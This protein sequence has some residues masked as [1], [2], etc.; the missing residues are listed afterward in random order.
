MA[1]AL[2]FKDFAVV[3]MA[4]HPV[5][6]G[7]DTAGMVNIYPRNVVFICD[8]L[9]WRKRRNDAG[10]EEGRAQPL[11]RW[12]SKESAKTAKFSEPINLFTVH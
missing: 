5:E 2:K 6:G 11:D 8:T 9:D 4:I 12:H 3:N 10:D 1:H 7:R